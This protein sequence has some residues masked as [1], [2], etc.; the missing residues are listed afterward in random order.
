MLSTED[1]LRT[2]GPSRASTVHSGRGGCLSG[3][4]RPETALRRTEEGH[5]ARMSSS[6][7][8]VNKHV[9]TRTCGGLSEVA[10]PGMVLGDFREM[11][12]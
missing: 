2:L 12:I 11:S 4:A 7:E 3:A 9:R 1:G 10:R 8:F 6:C 5:A